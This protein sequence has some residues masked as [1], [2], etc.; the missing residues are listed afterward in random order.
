[1]SHKGLIYKIVSKQTDKIYIG[2]TTKSLAVRLYYH[3][4]DKTNIT[5]KY[6][7]KYDDATIN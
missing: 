4:K 2:S 5:S 6:I 3:Y 1:M 7:L